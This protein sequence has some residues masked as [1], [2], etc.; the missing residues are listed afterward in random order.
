MTTGRTQTQN[1]DMEPGTA[2]ELYEMMAEIIADYDELNKEEKM[3]KYQVIEDNGGGL[4]LAVFGNHNTVEYLHDGYEY[5]PS[6]LAE[7]LVALRAG[8]TPATDWDGNAEDPQAMYDNITS[9]EYGWEIVADNDGIYPDKMGA[10][11]QREFNIPYDKD[12]FVEMIRDWQADGAPEYDN[13]EIEEPKIENGKWVAYTHD[14][15]TTYSLADDGTGN[16]V[17][18]YIGT[19]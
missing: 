16:I 11:A 10:A 3:K 9:Y 2:E 4:T 13:L 1:P 7:D 15:K 12:D 19:R 6:Q 5:A 17:I 8:D 18:N 14:G